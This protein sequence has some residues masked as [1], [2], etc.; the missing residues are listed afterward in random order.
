MNHNYTEEHYAELYNNL[1]EGLKDLVLSGRLA[2]Q[3]AA[4][5]TR[6]GLNPDQV[7]DLEPAV[8]D[9]C[10][11]LILKNQLAENIKNQV[12]TDDRVSNRIAA[13]VEIEIL[14]PFEP[15]IIIARQQKEDLDK[16]ISGQKTSQPLTPKPT[17]ALPQTETPA[18][19]KS[20]KK[21]FEPKDLS[22]H[23]NVEA[24][25]NFYQTQPATS[26]NAQE[27]K[28]NF[29][30]E[31]FGKKPAVEPE[32]QKTQPKEA[33]TQLSVDEKIDKLTDT[34]N[35]LVNN[36]F[37]SEKKD[38][39]LSEQMKELMRRLEVAE[40]ENAENKKLIKKLQADNPPS[41]LTN[42][43]EKKE[44]WETKNVIKI[45]APR[46]VGIEHQKDPAPDVT[47]RSIPTG[48][49]KVEVTTQNSIPIKKETNLYSSVVTQDTANTI[50][51]TRNKEKEMPLNPT[52]AKKVLSLDEL[53][54]KGD[55]KIKDASKNTAQ[56]VFPTVNNDRKVD[57][58]NANQA[59][60]LRQ[61]LLEDIEF[62]KKKSEP[63]MDKTAQ[64]MATAPSTVVNTSANTQAQKQTQTDTK[65][66]DELLPKTKEDRMR[67]LQDKIKSM[68]KGVSTGGA[69]SIAATA[70]DPYKI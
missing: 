50:V 3:V 43:Y 2:I 10:L 34:I 16:K 9:V 12:G 33:G 8:E 44:D 19:G 52:P 15:E 30:W 23:S 36:R 66:T 37:G 18:P 7:A 38:E 67:A 32:P 35:Q 1:P 4:I 68:N 58:K 25:K 64:A 59:D 31:N 46:N 42:F 51:E 21:E 60:T 49:V 40:K 17:S 27:N 55:E 53:I 61:T 70:L 6:H 62:L 69:N 57:I 29:D 39:G 22:E 13:E 28:A 5:G 20:A 24:I 63:S 14:R 48:N 65:L 26:N 45:D 56:I 11:G 41:N 54:K 47:T